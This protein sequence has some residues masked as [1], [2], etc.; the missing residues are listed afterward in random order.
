M[1]FSKFG[2]KMF[3]DQFQAQ[4]VLFYHVDSVKKNSKQ[5]RHLKDYGSMK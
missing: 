2:F 1:N 4:M 3:I 5:H